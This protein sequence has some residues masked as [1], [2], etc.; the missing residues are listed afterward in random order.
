MD[1]VSGVGVSGRTSV[2]GTF[3]YPVRSF[4]IFGFKKIFIL[5]KVVLLLVYNLFGGVTGVVIVKFYK[6]S[7]LRNI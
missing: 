5:S 7:E 4:Y 3:G 1:S 2:E 6:N